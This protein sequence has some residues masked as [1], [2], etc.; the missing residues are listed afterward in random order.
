MARPQP[1]CVPWPDSTR[2][3]SR[4]APYV[5]PVVAHAAVRYTVA[6]S[7]ATTVETSVDGR[8]QVKEK[9]DT[10][11]VT[12]AVPAKTAPVIT[13]AATAST[14][15]ASSRVT[16]PARPCSGSPL[17]AEGAVPGGGGGAA[18]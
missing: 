17:M 4:P 8:G 10:M 5:R 1:R 16:R 12:A 18:G 11:K 15:A 9:G 7:T 6:T 3:P 13:A 2:T 14:P